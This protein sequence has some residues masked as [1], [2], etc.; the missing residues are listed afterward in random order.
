MNVRHLETFYHVVRNRGINR[1]VG[2]M[3]YG[4]QQP[5][6]SEQIALLEQSMGCR[7]F[8]RQ[9][10][11]LTP[12][13]FDLYTGIRTHFDSVYALVAQIRRGLKLN[14]RIAAEEVFVR[15][16]LAGIVRAMT[17]RCPAM[18]FTLQSGPFAEMQ[19]WLRH[20]AVDMII[21]TLASAPPTGLAA[22]KIADLPL[23]LIVDRN[24][25]LQSADELWTTPA[26]VDSLIC[27]GAEEGVA[28]T[29]QRGLK[30][31]GVQWQ[32]KITVG[33]LE[34]VA[35][36]VQSGAGIGVSAAVPALA[37]RPDLRVLPLK[38][39]D[40]VQLTAL[41]QPPDTTRLKTLIGFIKSSAHLLLSANGKLEANQL[42]ALNP[43]RPIPE[44]GEFS[45]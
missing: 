15:H 26:I 4:L 12:E 30:R 6:I 17:E 34:S 7:L 44:N 37:G 21:T 23:V 28:Q 11:R 1:A 3:P 13:G 10:F 38:G 41:W 22:R 2:H 5:A 35:A 9:P 33:S 27:P 32:P 39:F 42:G 18:R 16:Y 24:S 40:P 8:D 19:Q 25:H 14:L 43:D 20:G 31:G 45:F 36:F 29:F